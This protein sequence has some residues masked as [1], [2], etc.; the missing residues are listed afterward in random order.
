MVNLKM[1]KMVN[2][3]MYIC[4]MHTHKKLQVLVSGET[5][6]KKYSQK[7]WTSMWRK[8]YPHHT[9][10]VILNIWK[11]NKHSNNSGEERIAFLFHLC[12]RDKILSN[13]R[14]YK[15]QTERSAYINILPC[16]EK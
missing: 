8:T 13:E 10:W 12:K 9:L 16:N 4:H 3:G 5:L 6:F 2:F 14:K 15:Q 7:N 11:T 1:V